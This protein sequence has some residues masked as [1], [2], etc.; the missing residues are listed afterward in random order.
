MNYLQIRVLE[1]R[2]LLARSLRYFYK[3]L[4]RYS[5]T[6]DFLLTSC[7]FTVELASD[8]STPGSALFKAEFKS[9]K[10]L[11]FLL[12]VHVSL[13]FLTSIRYSVKGFPSLSFT[14]VCLT[15]IS[16]FGLSKSLL[17]NL[18]LF[19]ASGPIKQTFKCGMN[20]LGTKNLVQC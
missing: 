17:S 6:S 19:K 5:M 1:T 8:S 9:Q 13:P 3:F 2:G 10:A 15:F 18:V 14:R 7:G 12:I 11:Y 16:S 20:I 4:R